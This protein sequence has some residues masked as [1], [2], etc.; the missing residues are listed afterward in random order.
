MLRLQP[1][2]G[3]DRGGR[4]G[5]RQGGAAPLSPTASRRS[6]L[7]CEL[8]RRRT[9]PRCGSTLPDAGRTG[10]DGHG[11]TRLRS[12]SCRTSR[13]GWG[14]W[15]GVTYLT[16]AFPLLAVCDD[17][18]WR[19][20]PFVPWH[21]PWFNEAG[22]FRATS[23]SPRTKKSRA[24]RRSRAKRSSATA[25]SASSASRSSAATSRCC[26]RPA[27]SEFTGDHEA[28]R[29]A[30]RSRCRCLAFPEHE[31]YATEILK[32]VGE[33]IPVYSQWFGAYP[34]SQFTVAESY[35]GWNGNECAGL[36]MID[37]RVFGMPHLAAGTSST[38]CRTRRAT[39]GGTTW[40]APTA[41][42][43]RSW[44]RAPRRTS[45]TGCST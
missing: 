9:P 30:A 10:A 17:T 23:P 32:I 25:R 1:S 31:F 4:H 2:L 37:E 18:G 24:R 20:M 36:V 38:S 29:R 16:N 19:P 40:S 43:S 22:V 6:P 28:P 12:A 44:T 14:H 41:T 33:A 5:R 34:Y 26:A 3:I 35:F 42:P 13:A 15:E 21:Q 27:T 8:R 11:R 45:R 39:S 7:T